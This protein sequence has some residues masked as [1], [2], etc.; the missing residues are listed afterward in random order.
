M[1]LRKFFIEIIVW[2]K[3][4]G[5]RGELGNREVGGGRIGGGVKG[6]F[7]KFGIRRIR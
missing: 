2:M 6:G 5:S 3:R 1:V 4:R 7:I